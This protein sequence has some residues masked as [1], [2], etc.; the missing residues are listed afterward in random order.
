MT[1]SGNVSTAVYFIDR[2][3]RDAFSSWKK[4]N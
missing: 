2:W 1:L 4:R 3:Q